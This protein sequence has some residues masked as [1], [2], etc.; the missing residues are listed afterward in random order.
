[1]SDS[2]FEILK[3][4][5][6]ASSTDFI[7]NYTGKVTKAI[8]LT[9][10]PELQT[11][12][13]PVKGFFKIIR[14]SPLIKDGSVTT[15]FFEAKRINGKI[16]YE[17]RPLLLSGN[18]TFEVG[19]TSDN[20][21]RIFSKFNKVQGIRTRLKFENT[22]IEYTIEDVAVESPNMALGKYVII[23]SIS[24]ALLPTP[25]VATQ[26]VRRFTITPAILLWVPYLISQQTYTVTEDLV[27]KAV[28]LL[29]TSFV[30]H[31]SSLAKVMHVLYD[32]RRE[33][34]LHFRAK[35]IVLCS[36]QERME[37]LARILMVARTLGV[38]ASRANGF[39]T[40]QISQK[41]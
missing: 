31:Y 41:N 11:V 36:D 39:G 10:V 13:R 28:K 30:E 32:G 24:P 8:L 2:G 37:T 29:E 23:K 4:K 40:V 22:V 15:P 35:Y 27:Y 19:S 20:V 6:T 3:V 5:V 21:S 18:Y 26:Q 16:V 34:A 7:Y 38:G 17:L 25:Y 14:V 9:E 33:P 12:F 1:M